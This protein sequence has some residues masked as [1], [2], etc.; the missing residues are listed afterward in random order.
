MLWF[1]LV[2]GGRIY[3]QHFTHHTTKKH[4]EYKANE[5]YKKLLETKAGIVK[6]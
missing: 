4:N 2:L 3:Y 5:T 6:V 1:M